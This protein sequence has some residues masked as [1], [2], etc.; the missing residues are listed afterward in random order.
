MNEAEAVERWFVSRGI[1][2]FI[3]DY[4]ATRDVFTR[5]LPALT[6][7]LLVE[8]VGAVNLNWPAWA[9][10]AA[11]AGGF[12][13]LLGA[14]ALANRLRHRPPFSRPEH[15]GA[16]ELTVFVLAPALLPL[17]F[18]GQVASATATAAANLGLLGGIYLATSYGLIPMTRWAAAQLAGQL[19]AVFGLLVRALPLLLLFVTFL[20][21][22]AEVWAV[23]D[24]MEGAFFW[25]VVGLFAVTGA[26]FVATR[27]PREVSELARFADCAELRRILS[28]TP[29]EGWAASDLPAAVPLSKRQWGNVGL[30]LLFTQGLQVLLVSVMIGAFFVLFGLLVMTPGIIESWTGA[31]LGD[32][33]VTFSLWGRTVPV[34]AELLRVAGF[35]AAFSGLYFAVYAVTDATYRQEFH[36]DVVAD[37]R[38]A[39][40]VRAV[41]LSGRGPG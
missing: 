14:W 35:L 24:A 41:Y 16:A 22:N 39:F 12:T 31:A 6:L 26:L 37:L 4:S 19:G 10:A 17:V 8:A 23:A 27:L 20:F 34:T 11:L 15:L 7:V 21:I 30:V 33:L 5:A 13:I 38:Q 29:A 28:G 2:H 36:D 3:A 40:A 9:N 32:P 18:G 25:A 1:P